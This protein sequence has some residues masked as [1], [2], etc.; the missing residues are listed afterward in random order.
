MDAKYVDAQWIVFQNIFST[1]GGNGGRLIAAR[2]VKFV[3]SNCGIWLPVSW[4]PGHGIAIGDPRYFGVC[5]IIRRY[6]RFSCLSSTDRLVFIGIVCKQHNVP[7]AGVDS[8]VFIDDHRVYCYVHSEDRLYLLTENARNLRRVG[9]RNVYPY[10]E[11]DFSDP[12]IEERWYYTFATDTLQKRYDFRRASEIVRMSIEQSSVTLILKRPPDWSIDRVT[13]TETERN[14]RL[15]SMQSFDHEYGTRNN[16]EGGGVIDGMQQ[17]F[18][19]TLHGRNN[20]VRLSRTVI[21][22]MRTSGFLVV[23]SIENLDSAV[24]VIDRQCRVYALLHGARLVKLSESL[25]GFLR[26]GFSWYE[27][28][29]RRRCCF[30]P[31]GRYDCPV[32]SYKSFYCEQGDYILPAERKL[33]ASKKLCSTQLQKTTA[34]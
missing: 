9:L 3:M 25:R 11:F 4:P 6:S 15:T 16:M 1:G 31:V 21:R 10:Y 20:P 13:A 24:I 28:L 17:F 7:T 19:F 8:E 29:G 30:S 33:F 34:V 27:S 23:G 2:L 14:P 32:G 12:T 26:C 5:S 18:L 22:S